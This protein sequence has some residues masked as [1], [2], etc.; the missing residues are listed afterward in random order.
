MLREEHGLPSDSQSATR[1]AVS[2][3]VAFMLAGAVPLIVFV[4]DLVVPGAIPGDAI[5][6][7]AGMTAVT[8]FGTG[9]VKARVVD[10]SPWSSGL[11][12]LALG[13]GAA[14]LAYAIGWLLSGLAT[15]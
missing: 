6:W 1:A 7:S 9:V 12:T 10:E 11:E 8:F 4:V 14:L 3:F 2:T 5:W 13:G 15:V